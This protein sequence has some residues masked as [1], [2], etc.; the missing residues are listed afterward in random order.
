MSARSTSIGTSNRTARL[1]QNSCR[2]CVSAAKLMVQV[3][4][5][6]D[7]ESLRFRDFAKRVQQRNRIC[8]TRQRNSDTRTAR[9]QSVSANGAADG[10]DESIGA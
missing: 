5:T 3:R 6:D 9:K 4:R 10:I 8:T 1:R 2:L 7:V